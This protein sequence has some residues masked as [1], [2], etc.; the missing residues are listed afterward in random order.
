[1]LISDVLLRKLLPPLI[2]KARSVALLITLLIPIDIFFS[3]ICGGVTRCLDHSLW[4]IG[5]PLSLIDV[6]VFS[7]PM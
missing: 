3:S 7:L 2:I 4:S 5:D 6:G 1:M